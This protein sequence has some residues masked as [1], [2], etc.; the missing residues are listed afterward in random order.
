[1]DRVR[2]HCWRFIIPE[3]SRSTLWAI[4]F[5]TQHCS[6]LNPVPAKIVVVWIQKPEARWALACWRHLQV[7]IPFLLNNCGL[8]CI[9]RSFLRFHVYCKQGVCSKPRK[10]VQKLQPVACRCISWTSRSHE[11][12]RTVYWLFFLATRSLGSNLFEKERMF[13]HWSYN[14]QL[15]VA[16]YLKLSLWWSASAWA[17]SKCTTCLW[18][19]S[20]HKHP[21]SLLVIW[22]KESLSAA[23]SLHEQAT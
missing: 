5:V 21:C 7:H 18:H 20:P 23:V 19:K 8:A 2:A 3:D 16:L 6:Q 12:Q 10:S 11:R 4:A 14:I 9:N 1:M 13:E 17:E 22:C 15:P